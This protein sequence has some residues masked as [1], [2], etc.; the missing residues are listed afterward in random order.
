MG[1]A[2]ELIISKMRSNT[3]Y[4]NKLTEYFLLKLK[5]TG[6]DFNINGIN[7]IPGVFNITFPEVAGQDLMINM[8]IEGIAISYGAACASGT[9]KP[10]GVLLE[11]GISPEH[12]KCSVRIS[13][14]KSNSMQDI[15]II[16]EKINLIISRIKKEPQFV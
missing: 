10:P 12:A 1:L 13:F 11:I 3:K 16:I 8:D 7:L 6:I 14:G 4:L 5:S 2:A 9:A 15:D